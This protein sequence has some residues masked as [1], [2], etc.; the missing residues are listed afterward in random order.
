[1]QRVAVA[2]AAV[3]LVGYLGIVGRRQCLRQI[4]RLL[5]VTPPAPRKAIGIENGHQL[6]TGV[7]EVLGQDQL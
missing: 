5:D 7:D 4:K 6:G 3:G 1:M 2:A